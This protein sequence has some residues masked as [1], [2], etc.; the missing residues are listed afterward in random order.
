MKLP[1]PRALGALQNA[2]ASIKLEPIN[3]CSGVT[4]YE[5]IWHIWHAACPPPHPPGWHWPERHTPFRDR[6]FPTT[7]TTH[8]HP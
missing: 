2:D 1:L 4:F 5:G 7:I 8:S 6:Q 3:D